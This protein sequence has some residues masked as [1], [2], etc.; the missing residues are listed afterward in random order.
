MGAGCSQE[1][2][3]Q[4]QDKA[5][6]AAS[7][8][9]DWY[10]E[11]EENM[12]SDET[13]ETEEVSETEKTL[14]QDGTH[15]YGEGFSLTVPEEWIATGR[16]ELMEHADG[17]V[18]YG[19]IENGVPDDAYGDPDIISISIM[20]MN[21]DEM[22]YEEIVEEFDWDQGDIDLRVNYMQENAHPPYN[23]ITGEDIIVTSRKV[24]L[25]NEQEVNYSEIRCEKIC[26]IEGSAMTLGMYFVDAGEAVYLLQVKVGTNEMTD[27]RLVMAADIVKTFTVE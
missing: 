11:V 22:T 13:K 10:A 8:V 27:E 7:T 18:G 20:S 5:S 12:V 15:V 21:K 23:E 26:Y 19:W 1:A 2:V 17:R 16:S 6:D 9:Q 24:I 14:M 3:T 4:W 25:D